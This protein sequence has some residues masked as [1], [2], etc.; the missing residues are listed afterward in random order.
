MGF[1]PSRRADARLSS[2]LGRPGKQGGIVLKRRSIG[3]NQQTA[4]ICASGR[5]GSSCPSLRFRRPPPGTSAARRIQ[6]EGWRREGQII[7]LSAR[8]WAQCKGSNSRTPGRSLAKR[9]A[10][11]MARNPMR[12]TVGEDIPSW[13]DDV[14]TEIARTP[15]ADRTHRPRPLQA[16]L[17][18][19]RQLSAPEVLPD[20][21]R[22]NQG[23]RICEPQKC[24]SG[25]IG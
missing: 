17:V 25:R 7:D 12:K 13:S 5:C 6:H 3:R 10:A 16:R 20:A 23:R 18:P 11:K 22:Q 15:L 19:Q 8:A 2:R 4:A 9:Q 1:W 24:Q 21:T 14:G